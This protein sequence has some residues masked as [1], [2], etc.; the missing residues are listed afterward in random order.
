MVDRSPSCSCLRR[1]FHSSDNS[2]A[3][4]F[5]IVRY[6][7]PCFLRRPRC[8]HF[9]AALVVLWLCR[10]FASCRKH[11]VHFAISEKLKP[12]RNCNPCVAFSAGDTFLP[13]SKERVCLQSA[14]SW[15]VLK[16][17]EN[18]CA[19]WHIH[20][21]HRKWRIW[22][23]QKASV[24]LQENNESKSPSTKCRQR[25]VCAIQRWKEK[26]RFFCRF[27]TDFNETC[28]I[29]SKIIQPQMTC[30]LKLFGY[31]RSQV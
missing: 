18:F 11:F 17:I 20:N 31:Q 21:K 19:S 3:P 10:F 25:Y 9:S 8:H 22:F 29:W 14:L 23:S 28:K 16:S 12:Y 7:P 13:S 1:S 26:E 30:L 2:I 5:E 24:F 6:F 27:L 15:C 4:L